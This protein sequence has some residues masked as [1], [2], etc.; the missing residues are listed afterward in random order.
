M[1]T[2]SFPARLWLSLF[3]A[4]YAALLAVWTCTVLTRVPYGDL[5]RVGRLPE[6]EFGWRAANG[7]IPATHLQATSLREADVVVIG[8]SFSASR[9]WQSVLT[10]AGLKVATTQWDKIGGALC[11][12]FRAWLASQG[13]RGHTVVIQTIQRR[14][15]LRAELSGRCSRMPHPYAEVEPSQPAPRDPPPW[16][17]NS[18]AKL[19]TGLVTWLN[20]RQV[21]QVST[22]LVFEEP[23]H[24]FPLV[25][26][27]TVSD[28]C[29][30]FS[31]ALCERV[32]LFA[33]DIEVDVPGERELAFARRTNAEFARAPHAPRLVWMVVPDKTT[34]YTAPERGAAFGAALHA[35][36][37]GP[38]LFADAQQAKVATRDFYWPNDTHLSTFGMLHVGA[39]MQQ[40]IRPVQGP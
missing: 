22:E 4:A 20:G 23:D 31:H 16:Q 25:R 14:M 21:R 38:D 11:A 18:T 40:W 32:L 1:S 7:E 33:E 36:G 5:T 27:R 30:Y 35:E 12:D 8:D 29:Q 2:T 3:G 19:S 39:L 6:S 37:L 17:W 10:A 15:V 26:V 28:G 34:V 9:A 13:F 24:E